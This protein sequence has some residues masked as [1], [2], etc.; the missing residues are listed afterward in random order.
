M[1]WFSD[2]AGTPLYVG[3]AKRL[4]ARLRSY[5]R[6]A[7]L[8]PKIKQ[9]VSTAK[10][11]HYTELASELEALLTETELIKIYQPKFN[12]LAKDDKSALY[13]SLS[14]DE[15]PTLRQVRK[16]QLPTRTERSHY[17]GPFPS[18][19][20]VKQILKIARPLFRWCEQPLPTRPRGCFYAQLGLCS[21][22][23]QGKVTTAQYREQIAQLRLFLAGR[24]SALKKQL[25]SEMR[26][27]A[28]AQ[29][30]EEAA[31]TRDRLVMLREVTEAPYQL[32][33]DPTLLQLA[34][35]VT[36]N[37]LAYLR[38]LLHLYAHCPTEY[39]L[40]RIEGYD[41]SNL[42]GTNAAVGMVV[43]LAGL[44]AQDHYRLFNIRSLQT[45]NDPGMLQE[46]IWRRQAH[47][48]WGRPDLLV[49]DGGEP[50]LRAV[51][52][53]LIWPIPVLGIAK[54]PDRLLLGETSLILPDHH[55]ALQLVRLVRDEA[56]RFSKNQHLR[57]RKRQLLN[58]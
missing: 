51:R 1:Y 52:A 4:K 3:K 13:I 24:S 29:A 14:R 32:P 37:Q 2:A 45:P 17:F 31:L 23:C 16:K 48:E 56:H 27:Q 39:P 30:Y 28:Q 53:A 43:F 20:R 57:L 10:Q 36:D 15:L 5:T 34:H 33:P 25:K 8:S 38:R 18:A 58:F 46:A 55:P 22:I 9:L 11:V 40:T 21:G 50:Q 54:R 42:S 6:F 26:R 7:D 19:Y 35:S 47:P 12:S 41:V 44:S 49:I